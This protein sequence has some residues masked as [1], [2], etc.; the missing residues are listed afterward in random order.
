MGRGIDERITQYLLRHTRYL[1]RDIVILGNLLC[2]RLEAS[3]SL[4][5]KLTIEDLVR[6]TVGEVARAF[7]NEQLTICGNQIASDIMPKHAA[8]RGFADT[9][10]SNM[11]YIGGITDQLRAFIRQIGKEEFSYVELQ[12]ARGIACDFFDDSTDPFTVL[13]QNGLLGYT[14]KA[15]GGESVIFYSEFSVDDFNIPADKDSYIFQ[16]CVTDALG[17]SLIRIIPAGF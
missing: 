5:P 6:D 13:W 14:K 2:Q 9:Y 7:G 3:A 16:S 11:E 17:L 15:P 4:T 1:P 12:T 8:I 10:T